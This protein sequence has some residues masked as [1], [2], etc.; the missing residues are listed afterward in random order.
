MSDFK[1]GDKVYVSTL[2]KVWVVVGINPQ[3]GSVVCLRD[4][5]CD[6]YRGFHPCQL[7]IIMSGEDLR[8]V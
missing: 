3:S 1:N 6:F 2:D 5:Y 7:K 8:K 4:G